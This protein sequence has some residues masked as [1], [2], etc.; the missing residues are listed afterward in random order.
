MQKPNVAYYM[1]I[2]DIERHK[3]LL[4]GSKNYN[5]EIKIYMDIAHN[6]L[7]GNSHHYII[8]TSNQYLG[9]IPRKVAILL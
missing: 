6:F 5:E 9:Y 4:F 7:D 8:D 3:N 2:I 1:F